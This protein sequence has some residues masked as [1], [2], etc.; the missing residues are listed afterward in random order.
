[1]DTLTLLRSH[2]LPSARDETAD[3]LL[4]LCERAGDGDRSALGELFERVADDLYGFALWSCGSADVAGDALA[5]LF[6]RLVASR[7]VL[8]Y[9]RKP[10]LY[11]L[12]AVS[13]EARRLAKRRDRDQPFERAP[14]LL[15]ESAAGLEA[16]YDLQRA[17]LRLPRVQREALYLR[18]FA[19]LELAEIGRATGVP[20]FTAA[21]RC[22]L[23]LKRLRKILDDAP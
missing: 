22:R 16:R 8:I 13:R 12:R 4:R 11:L 23:G 7:H 2:R 15:D 10:H 20:K 1:M 6:A 14:F 9:V 3:P 19:G 18:F 21:S 5:A 17:L